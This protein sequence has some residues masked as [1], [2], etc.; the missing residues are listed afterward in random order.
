MQSTHIQSLNIVKE[1]IISS[2]LFY[3][4]FF[5]SMIPGRLQGRSLQNLSLQQ[6]I[7]ALVCGYWAASGRLSRDQ[8]NKPRSNFF[9]VKEPWTLAKTDAGEPVNVHQ[10]PILLLQDIFTSMSPTDA[11]VLDA[12]SGTGKN[13]VHHTREI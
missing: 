9:D 2:N 10:K 12:C 1:Q 13:T 3:V 5:F 8:L 6:D 4:N 11:R 7:G